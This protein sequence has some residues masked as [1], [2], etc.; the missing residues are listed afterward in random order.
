MFLGVLKKVL[1]NKSFRCAMRSF[2]WAQPWSNVYAETSS[3]LAI[4]CTL[5]IENKTKV[6]SYYGS[7][8]AKS[9]TEIISLVNSD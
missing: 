3:M 1:K 2:H 8:K 7:L 4:Q 5:R 9:L 6:V